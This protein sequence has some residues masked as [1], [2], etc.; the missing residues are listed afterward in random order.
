ME[1]VRLILTILL[2]GC[3]NV[4]PIEG[5]VEY[6]T[7]VC[8]VQN[9]CGLFMVPDCSPA[10][11]CAFQEYMDCFKSAGC[12]GCEGEWLSYLQYCND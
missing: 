6:D 10:C 8:A 9:D 4:A 2:I 7:D 12:Q 5:D 3:S 11:S 1:R